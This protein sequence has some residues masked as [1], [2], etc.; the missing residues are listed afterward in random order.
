MQLGRIIR[1]LGLTTFQ[2]RMMECASACALAFMGGVERLAEP[3]SIGVHKSSFSPDST[4]DAHAAVSLVQELT[5]EVLTYMA[6]MGVGL[7][8]MQLALKTDSN[9]IRYL[10]GQEMDDFQLTTRGKPSST[11]KRPARTTSLPAPRQ[12]PLPSAEP[13]R[14]QIPVAQTGWVRHPKQSVVLKGAPDSKSFDVARLHNGTPVAILGT[15]GRW[16]KVRSSGYT[17]YMHHTWVRVDQFDGTPGNMRLIQIKSYDNLD[18]ALSY[19]TST[20]VPASVY[21]ATN[22]W[23]AVTVEDMFELDMALQ[24][25]KGLKRKSLIPQDSFVTLGNTYVV[26][27]C[28]SL[29]Q[30]PTSSLPGAPSPQS[31]SFSST[32]SAN[33]WLR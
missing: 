26:K 27:L 3:G 18:D 22:G 14:S 19:A 2:L 11:K 8:L 10:S 4:L 12:N 17:G 29:A 25:T 33:G 28:C 1:D 21:L 13:T 6:E 15:A 24:M 9:D 5:A 16:Y 30:K 31:N 7:D 20:G 23:F 32:R